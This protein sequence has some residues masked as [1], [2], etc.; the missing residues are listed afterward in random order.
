[1]I[2]VLFYRKEKDASTE[3]VEKKSRE[4]K[5]IV[6]PTHRSQHICDPTNVVDENNSGHG[7]QVDI[8]HGDV[9]VD[10]S[11]SVVQRNDFLTKILKEIIDQYGEKGRA[12]LEMLNVMYY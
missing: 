2:F 7:V 8:A 9:E 5:D 4:N 11:H 10:T 3:K 6:P 12:S 1:M